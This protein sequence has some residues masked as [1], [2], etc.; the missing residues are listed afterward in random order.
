MKVTA[1]FVCAITGVAVACGAVIFTSSLSKTNDHQSMCAAKKL[2]SQVPVEKGALIADFQL[3]YRPNRKV[4]QGPPMRAVVATKTSLKEG[5]LVCKSLFASRRIAALPSIGEELVLLGRKGAYK[6]KIAG[7][8][9]SGPSPRF[10]PNVFISPKLASTMDE[11]WRESET[12]SLRDLAESL[13]S[14]AQSNI[15]RSGWMLICGAILTSI[16]LLINS[17]FISIESSRREI[18]ILRSLGMSKLSVAKKVFAESASVSFAGFAVGALLSISSLFVYVFFDRDTF[19]MGAAVDFRSLLLVLAAAPS[20]AAVSAL[21]AL[22]P[23]FAVK[24]LE[25]SSRGAVRKRSVGMLA[26]FAVGFGA[27]VAVEVW[28]V[29]LTEPFVPSKE[30]PSAIVSILPAGVSS[31]DIGKLSSVEGVRRI[32]ELQ[33]LQ[34]NVLPL[35]ELPHPKRRRSQRG[36][37]VKH[38][39]NVLLLAS[40]HLPDFKFHSGVRGEAL[41]KLRR[42]DACVI[43][44]MMA[45]AR[46]LKLGDRLEL[47]CGG[48]HKMTLEIVGVVDLNWHMVTSRA[49]LRGLNRMSS[50]TDGPVFVSFDTLA[51]CDHRPQELV[52][53]THLWLDYEEDFILKHGVFEAG[54]KVERSIVEA[55]DG[56]YLKDAGGTVRGNTVRLHSRDEVA[57]GTLSHSSDLVGAMARIPFV[58]VVVISLGFVAMLVSSAESR[59]GEFSVLRSVG[60]TKLMLAGILV[61]EALAVSVSA[62]CF[63]IPGGSVLGWLC[64]WVTRA[65]M[66]NWGLPATFSFPFVIIVKG[67]LFAVFFAL[68]V[69][70][71]ASIVIIEK[72]FRKKG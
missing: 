52:K 18:A 31:F 33:P 45:N 46:K 26:A 7:F 56:A 15:S 58:F 14:D 57:D 51:A 34:V 32:S 60:A 21:F 8:I 41:K 62:I 68:L 37:K 17:L 2:M 30:W 71:P 5:A 39:R 55:L 69:A 29:S 43:T 49:L 36:K 66:P 12:Y 64:T 9:D 67:A 28:G 11:T 20:V 63:A 23:A 19:P 27:F 13:E 38:Y 16:C 70:I 53:M 24:P 35:E 25:I 1:R 4:M 22:V 6:V 72:K 42:E 47:D 65:S 61:K 48:S 40:S 59:K 3:D 54:R 10:Y 50:S 44:K